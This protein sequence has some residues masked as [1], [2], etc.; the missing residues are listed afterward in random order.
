MRLVG[1]IVVLLMVV[2]VALALAVVHRHAPVDCTERVVVLQGPHGEP[3]E[4]VCD[5]GVL[6]TCFNPGP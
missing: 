6:S 4:C 3:L 2:A 1:V 5:A